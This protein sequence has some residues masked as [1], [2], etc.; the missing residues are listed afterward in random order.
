MKKILIFTDGGAIGNPGPAA[1]GVVIKNEKGKVLTSFGKIIG[2][3]TNN[4]AEYMGVI[5]ALRWITENV[6][7]RKKFSS[8][9]S[10]QFFLDSRLVVNQINGLFKVKNARLRDL[11]FQV[12]QLEQTVGGQIAYQHVPR[13]QNA[14]AD[15]EVKKALQRISSVSK[16][17]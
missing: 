2:S 11:L 12:R 13:E 1:V 7:V 14:L 4:V 6:E 15:A 5:E 16:K 8:L 9:P 17:S 10:L 3:T